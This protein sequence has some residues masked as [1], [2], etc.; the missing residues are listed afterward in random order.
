[1]GYGPSQ[2][3]IDLGTNFAPSSYN[4]SE[5]IELASNVAVGIVTREQKRDIV[6]PS[7]SDN[8]GLL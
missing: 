5:C 4:M 2:E 3:G 1:M 7:T 6:L 8:S